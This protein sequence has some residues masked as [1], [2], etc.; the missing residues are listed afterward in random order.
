MIAPS[1]AQAISITFSVSSIA[2]AD[3]LQVYECG[4]ILCLQSQLLTSI[5]S[6]GSLTTNQIS[7]TG[8][9]KVL[10]TS[11]SYD[12]G[13][14]GGFDASWS[15]VRKLSVSFYLFQVNI[16]NQTGCKITDVINPVQSLMLLLQSSRIYACLTHFVTG[17]LHLH[18]MFIVWRAFCKI[19]KFRDRWLGNIKLP[20]Q[21]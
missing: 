14:K 15:S 18:R 21:C 7:A 4:D 6:T 3:Y 17:K 12:V 8:F 5:S 11:S 9:V 2:Y 20:K 10:F 19:W 16:Y 1:G 13:G